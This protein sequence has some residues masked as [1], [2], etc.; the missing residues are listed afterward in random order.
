MVKRHPPV[1]EGQAVRRVLPGWFAPTCVLLA[2]HA[3]T[4]TPAR[5]QTATPA[6]IEFFE[7]KVR[8]VLVESCYRCHSTKAKHVKGGLRLDSRAAL[9]QG[10]DSGPAVMPGQPTKSKLIQ[11]VGYTDADLHMP[12]R[13]KLPAQTIADLTRWVQ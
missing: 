6:G 8:P 3:V 12:P 9:L 1:P 10:G 11:A 7:K 4:M 13:G 2:A 5:A